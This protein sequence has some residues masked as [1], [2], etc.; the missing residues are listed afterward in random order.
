MAPIE[1]KRNR[2]TD[3]E[4]ILR[5]I[6]QKWWILPITMLLGLTLMFF[7]ESD[8]QTSPR[9]FSLTKS[10]EPLD[11]AGPLSI[12]GLDPSLI[13]PF[14]SE[15]NQ[16]SILLNSETQNEILGKIKGEVD[17][18]VTR[19]E[20]NFSLTSSQ[21]AEGKNQFS[22]VSYGSSSYAFACVEADPINCEAAIDLYVAK[23]VSIRS[24]ATKSGLQN[25]IK[26][27]DS[28]LASP[29]NISTAAIE[30][31]TLQRDA[32][33]KSIELVT[34]TVK[35]VGISQYSGGPEVTSVSKSTYLFGLVIGLVIGCLILLQ[36]VFSDGKVRGAKQ[37]V[38]LVGYKQ[39]L[40]ELSAKNQAISLQHLAA[41]IQGSYMIK[42][43]TV[44]RLVAIGGE[45]KSEQSAKSLAK[46]LSCK[47]VSVGQINS[48]DAKS[49]AATTDSPVI[50]LAKKHRSESSE[51]QNAWTVVEKSGNNILGVILVG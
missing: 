47:I 14:P 48:L 33:N 29:R 37:L 3:S 25:S 15:E 11:E 31:L 34:G 44:L 4:T 12:V 28:L 30:K 49:L 41:A 26:L 7:Q 23:L 16:L 51:L 1:T 35:L 17:V 27:I 43:S 21:G 32:L 45:V 22:F 13:K 2:F 5:V 42:K 40:G 24:E 39:F 8:L 38:N 10:Y 19:S 20:P 18:T 50:L 36:L 46:I 6:S 9:Y